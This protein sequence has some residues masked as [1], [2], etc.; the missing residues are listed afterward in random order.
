MAGNIS[1]IDI[2]MQ[3]Q[4]LQQYSKQSNQLHGAADSTMFQMSDPTW[5]HHGAGS[6]NRANK[7]IHTSFYNNF[8]D[9]FDDEDLQ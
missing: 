5:S 6:E 1:N 9:D 2:Q 8:D 7:I 3:Q 4:L